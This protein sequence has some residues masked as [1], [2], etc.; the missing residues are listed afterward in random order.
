MMAKLIEFVTLHWME[1]LVASQAMLGA[2]IAIFMLV[3]GPQ[4]EKAMQAVLD[5]ITQ[6]SRKPKE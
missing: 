4:P 1:I 5:F 6:L 2:M 3:P